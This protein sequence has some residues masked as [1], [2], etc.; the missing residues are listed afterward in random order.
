MTNR[1]TLKLPAD[2]A[3]TLIDQVDG[4]DRQRAYAAIADGVRTAQD[5][6]LDARF[7]VEALTHELVTLTQSRG[8]NVQVAA[9]LRA[10]AD[11]LE[12]P[13]ELH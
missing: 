13:V 2:E 1:R 11:A 7:I 12:A 9:Q 3:Q 5:Q 10:L 4:E 6:W 8:S